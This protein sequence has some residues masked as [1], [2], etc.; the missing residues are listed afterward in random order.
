[1]WQT[2]QPRNFTGQN[3]TVMGLGLFG[4]GLAATKFL[5][6]RGAK[7]TVTDLQTESELTESIADLNQLNTIEFRLGCHDEQDFT[8]ADLIVANPAVKPGNRFLETAKRAG[9]PITTELG[10]FVESNPARIIAVTGSNGKSTTAAMIHHVLQAKGLRTHLGG[11]I[12]ESLL[13]KL[14]VIHKDDWVVL[15]VS[16]F[17][18]WH[19]SQMSFAPHVAVVT[20]FTANH[21]DWHGSLDE[22]RKAKQALIR[23]QVL[24]QTAILNGDDP[25][26]K[27]W[28][29]AAHTLFF[30]ADEIAEWQ[31]ENQNQAS[32]SSVWNANI[33]AAMKACEAVGISQNDAFTA[34]KSFHSLPHRMEVVG[35]HH[36]RVFVNDSASTTPE[37]TVAALKSAKAPTILLFGGASKGLSMSNVT[38]AIRESCKAIFLYGETGKL[39]AKDLESQSWHEKAVIHADML[40]AF[41]DATSHSQEGDVILFSPGSTS[42]GEFR[43]FHDRG[44]RF[45]ELVE[46]FANQL[47]D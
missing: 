41:K 36:G 27:Q 38:R 21:L 9:I 37:S 5:A 17:Q 47:I 20:N 23:H 25:D 34:L 43:N 15:E 12:G 10:L 3:V 16:S 4:G 24:D 11:N 6:E 28:K 30:T 18:L 45:R 7:V 42:Y 1:M 31:C 39:V 14:E 40:S 29:T 19:L 35:V 13:N 26:M 44:V 32:N 22:Y 2:S 8:N 46:Q 33:A